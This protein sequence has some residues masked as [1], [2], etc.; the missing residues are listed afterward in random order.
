VTD[1]ILLVDKPAARSSHD[2]VAVVRRALGTRKVGHAGTLDPMA[3]G[4]LVCA[5]GEGLKV[6]RYL[7]LDAKRYDAVVRLGTETDT[8]DAEGRVVQSAPV[9]PDL[10]L[11]QVQQVARSFEGTILQ[12]VP[13]ISALKRDGQPLYVRARRGE[14]VEPPERVA[15]VYA[16]EID[17]VRE[18]EIALRVHCGKGF[19]V[20]ALARDLSRALGTV[21]HLAALRRTQCGH[22]DL[23]NA[24]ALPVALAAASGD[25]AARRELAQAVLPIEQALAGAPRFV[26]DAAGTEHAR[27]GRPIAVEHVVGG[28]APPADAELEPVL[29]CS[30]QGELLALASCAHATFRVVRGLRLSEP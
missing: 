2:I 26:L 18:G 1:G 5:V 25:E 10:T 28:G 9:P 20:R 29:L 24:V 14:S 6:L 3:T 16:L 17:A 27:Q 30:E 7:A 13:A 21:G 22:F 12:R 4:L 11:E 19:Y 23:A 8:L 15:Q